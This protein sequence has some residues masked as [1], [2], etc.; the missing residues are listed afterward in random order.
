MQSPPCESTYN[1]GN[2]QTEADG[3]H[4]RPGHRKGET[5][6]TENHCA[7]TGRLTKC[8]P[9]ASINQNAVQ[10]SKHKTTGGSDFH[11]IN[12]GGIL[13]GDVGVTSER[14]AELRSRAG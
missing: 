8:H 13:P 2:H 14:L 12:E 11:R 5:Q 4:Q 7:P 3:I 9:T 6:T 1:R 10:D